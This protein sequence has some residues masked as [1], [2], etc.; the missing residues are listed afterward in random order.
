[1][2]GAHRLIRVKDGHAEVVAGNG[3]KG[4]GGDGGP[5]KGAEL[6]SPHNIAITP[7]G[8]IFIADTFNSRVRR[9]DGKSG[10]ISTFAG[11]GK[12]AFGGDGGTASAADF[13]NIYCIAFDG[14]F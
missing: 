5:A 10:V 13:G 11:T 6:N 9:I 12:R 2:Y 14:K 1:E 8:D 4:F 7:G 3:E